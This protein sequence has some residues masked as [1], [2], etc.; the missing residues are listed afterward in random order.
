MGGCCLECDR[1]FS[2]V[3]E[4]A[5]GSKEWKRL[6]EGGRVGHGPQTDGSAIEE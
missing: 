2:P 4:L 5:G 3:V 1:K 6:E